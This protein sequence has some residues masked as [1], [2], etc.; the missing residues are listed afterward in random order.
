MKLFTLLKKPRSV[1]ELAQKLG[2]TT[3]NAR[4]YLKRYAHVVKRA[5]TAKKAHGA[6]GP[7]GVTYVLRDGAVLPT[8]RGLGKSTLFGLKATTYGHLLNAPLAYSA[9]AYAAGNK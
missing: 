4:A 2:C 1:K 9:E 7:A 5:G 6:P 8:L 3:A